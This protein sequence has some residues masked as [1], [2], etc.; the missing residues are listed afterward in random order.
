MVQ[1]MM[2]LDTPK[3]VRVKFEKRDRLQYISHLDLNRTFSHALVRAKIPVWYTMGFNPHTKMTFATP[4]SV[5]SES[6]CEYMDIKIVKDMTPEE[7]KVALSAA[8][9][10][11]LNIVDVYFPETKFNDIAWSEYEM[12]LNTASAGDDL[13]KKITALFEADEIRVIKHT[14]SGEKEADIK[15]YILRF[16]CELVG[17]SLF[18]RTTL[19]CDKQNFLNPEY[20]M[21]VIKEKLG[22]FSS[23]SIDE[24]YSIMRREVYF[25]DGVTPFR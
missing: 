4:L 11:G 17:D 18:I 7:I 21:K 5:G 22:L 23:D 19:C 2:T 12:T 13:A 15:P 14:K 3:A 24:G 8:F 6:V 9:A 20:L 25:A 1:E 10:P 16:S